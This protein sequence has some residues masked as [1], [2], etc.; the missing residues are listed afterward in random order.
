VAAAGAVVQ[1]RVLPTQTVA[2]AEV[3]VG[4]HQQQMM[5]NVK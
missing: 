4:F 3:Q 5:L 2:V 1:Y